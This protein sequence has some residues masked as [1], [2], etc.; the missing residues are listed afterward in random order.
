MVKYFG[1]F[2]IKKAEFEAKKK[3]ELDDLKNKSEFVQ[4]IIF[5]MKNII[6]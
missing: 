3:V 1:D 5:M 4:K 2:L 6:L